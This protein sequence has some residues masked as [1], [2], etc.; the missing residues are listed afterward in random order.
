MS[1]EDFRRVR[2]GMGLWAGSGPETPIRAPTG[3]TEATQPH[4]FKVPA[5]VSSGPRALLQRVF[6][7]TLRHPMLPIA[8]EAPSF[9]GWPRGGHSSCLSCSLTF[10][11]ITALA[12]AFAFALALAFAGSGI[13]QLLI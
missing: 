1:L 9:R 5:L 10:S 4:F 8:E 3:A 13:I 6:E 11:S 2:V 7:G 12:L